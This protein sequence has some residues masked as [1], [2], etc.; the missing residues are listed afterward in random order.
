MSAA[1]DLAWLLVVAIWVVGAFRNKRTVRGMPPLKL[2]VHMLVLAAAFDLLFAPG[3]RRGALA[4]RVLPDRGWIEDLGGVLQIAGLAFCIWARLHIGRNW[5][6]TVTL[7]RAHPGAERAVRM[8]AA[9]DL[10]GA[11]GGGTGEGSQPRRSGRPAGVPAAGCG[12]EAEVDDGRAA[13]AGAVRR[14]L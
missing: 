9:S 3:L 2:I 4:Y 6:G 1:A 10:H 12:V 7:G 11:A 8:G 5:S 14:G 13:D